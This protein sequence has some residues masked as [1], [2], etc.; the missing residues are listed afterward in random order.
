MMWRHM[1]GWRWPVFFVGLLFL[2]LSIAKVMFSTSPAGA[3]VLMMVINLGGIRS[4]VLWRN[5]A[6]AALKR[7]EGIPK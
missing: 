3:W 5:R 4:Y 2:S 7:A 6:E 1:G